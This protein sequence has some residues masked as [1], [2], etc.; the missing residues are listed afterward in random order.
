MLPRCNQTN[1]TGN[2]LLHTPQATFVLA[3]GEERKS[4][5]AARAGKGAS[6]KYMVAW[7]RAGRGERQAA[8]NWGP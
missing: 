8:L 6:I 4:C 7:N 2:W 5:E 1:L 3:I